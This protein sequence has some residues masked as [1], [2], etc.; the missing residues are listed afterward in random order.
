M[1]TVATS[2]APPAMNKRFAMPASIAAM[3][4]AAVFAAAT[5]RA[6]E[7]ERLFFRTKIADL[8]LQDGSIAKG[9]QP[10]DF[11]Q[12]V[13]PGRLYSPPIKL[14][15]AKK[16][17]RHDT[18]LATAAADFSANKA[19]DADWIL[20][21]FAPGDRLEVLKMLN[22]SDI[23][24]RNRGIFQKLGARY[25]TG[26]ASYQ[27]YLLLFVADGSPSADPKVMTVEKAAGGWLRTNALSRDET[28]DVVWAA[29]RSG[30]VKAVK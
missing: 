20:S 18:P 12:I 3:L 15:P 23:R 21:G 2:R 26:E 25:V 11:V 1:P 30:S 28:F 27:K 13:L 29:L 7:P 9:K 16:S 24:K 17:S 14:P 5:A 22:D 8:W 6:Q 10:S 4:A 19:D